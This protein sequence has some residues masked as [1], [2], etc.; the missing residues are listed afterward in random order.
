[1]GDVVDGPGDAVHR[2]VDH[3]RDRPVWFGAGHRGRI[4]ED[5]RRVPEIVDLPIALGGGARLPTNEKQHD[6]ADAA[7]GHAGMNENPPTL[8]IAQ[9]RMRH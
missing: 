5:S 9:W 1:M 4:R 3:I 7:S 2:V 8:G 6:I